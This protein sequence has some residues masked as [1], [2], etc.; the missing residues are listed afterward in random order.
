MCKGGSALGLAPLWLAQEPVHLL[1]GVLLHRLVDVGVRLQGDGDVGM[2]G[3]LANN[4][5]V[6]PRDQQERRGCVAEV[7]QA[8][9]R[10]P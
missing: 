7:V 1:G 9:G 2:P 4:L 10:T 6:D 3:P 5:G 8:N